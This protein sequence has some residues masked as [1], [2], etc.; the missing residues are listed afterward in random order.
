MT[1]TISLTHT[2]LFS[3]SRATARFVSFFLVI[4]CGLT[5][6]ICNKT[7]SWLELKFIKQ[8]QTYVC[9]LRQLNVQS[10]IYQTIFEGY[11]NLTR[12]PMVL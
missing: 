9:P 11:Q 7:K 4:D 10:A 12:G 5:F 3:E 6:I 1:L 2:L 8:V